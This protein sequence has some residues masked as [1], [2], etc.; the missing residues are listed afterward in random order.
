LITPLIVLVDCNQRNNGG[1]L[2]K[3][4]ERYLNIPYS[5]LFNPSLTSDEK[6]ILS[7][8][9]SLNK[10]KNGCTKSDNRFAE[11]INK[12]RQTANGIS[13]KLEKRGLIIKNRRKGRGKKTSLA[14]N[15]WELIKIPVGNHDTSCTNNIP[16]GVG[17]SDT[18]C[19]DSLQVGVDF[20]DTTCRDSDTTNTITNTDILLQEEL[21]Y[22]GATGDSIVEY[23]KFNMLLSTDPA[24][25]TNEFLLDFQYCSFKLEEVFGASIFEQMNIRKSNQEIYQIYNITNLHGIRTELNFV[26]DNLARF[27]KYESYI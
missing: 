15:F 18:T 14:A 11:I 7:E 23:Q 4:S 12:S 25:I 1:F 8:I 16:I 26:K 17:N 27:L 22:T 19:R 24:I 3:M 2:F 5:I 13:N 21:Q 10:L 6:L 9:I 20:H